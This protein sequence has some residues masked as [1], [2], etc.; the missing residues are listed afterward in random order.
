[1][2][3]LQNV[4]VVNVTP[5]AAIK[6]NASFATTT[7][8]TLGFNK[9]A[10]YFALGATDIAMTALKV[11]ESDDSGMSGAA[12]IT[13]AV[14][15][16]TGYAALPTADDDNKVFAFFIDL[17]GRKRYLDVVATAG[18]GSTGTFGAC[19]AH[20]YNPLTTEDNAT[21]RGLAA[22]LIV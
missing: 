15:G 16:A 4:K 20:L 2:N 13:G 10:I 11:Q 8:D 21:Q 14:Y 1:M 9:V 22:N 6:D 18:D 17:K 19:T 5:P 7:I 12:D 3:N